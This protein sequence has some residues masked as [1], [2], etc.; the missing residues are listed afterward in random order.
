MKAIINQPEFQK[1]EVTVIVETQL[2]LDAL[3]ALCRMD[4]TIP[5][6]VQEEF[7]K[8]QIQITDFLNELQ[9]TI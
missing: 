7:G 1:K 6:A 5:N 8:Y 9:K 3:D 2:E 4:V